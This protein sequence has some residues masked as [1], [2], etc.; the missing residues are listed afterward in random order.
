MAAQRAAAVEASQDWII[1]FDRHGIGTGANLSCLTAL[2][3][4]ATQVVGQS[5][6]D[7]IASTADADAARQMVMP[8]LTGPDWRGFCASSTQDCG[9][10][11]SPATAEVTRS[12]TATNC[13]TGCWRSRSW[14]TSC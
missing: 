11:S 2:Q 9:S 14:L 7:A 3:Q 4:P 5:L 10:C 1:T 12:M 13:S 8:A 6:R